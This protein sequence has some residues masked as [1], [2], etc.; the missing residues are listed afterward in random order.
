MPVSLSY[1]TEAPGWQAS[2]SG[3]GGTYHGPSGI[4]GIF[5]APR[6]GENTC[7][8]PPSRFGYVS[9][10]THPSVSFVQAPGI[11]P[12]SIWSSFDRCGK[13]APAYPSAARSAPI[14]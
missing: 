3:L 14:P 2:F 4:A 11:S 5:P 1:P 13:F 9:G 12:L 8:D 6:P 10:I 7:P